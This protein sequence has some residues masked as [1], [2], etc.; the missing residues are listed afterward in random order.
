MIFHK[1]IVNNLILIV[2]YLIILPLCAWCLYTAYGL[3][4]VTNSY[5]LLVLY[6]ILLLP[7]TTVLMVLS[8][9]SY[10][11]DLGWLK[12]ISFVGM[13]IGLLTWLVPGILLM[14]RLIEYHV[15]ERQW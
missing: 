11:K 10:K 8:Y 7:F 9:F 6:I 12:K 1:T 2:R 14:Y 3:F 13:I 4:E 15:F 5:E